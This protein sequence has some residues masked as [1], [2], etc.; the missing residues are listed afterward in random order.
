MNNLGFLIGSLIFS[1]FGLWV[2]YQ[3]I[4]AIVWG[5]PSK[6]WPSTRGKIVYSTIERGPR[7][8]FY[9]K[10]MFE[11]KVNGVTYQSSRIWWG[12]RLNMTR[13][14]AE[15][16]NAEYRAGKKVQV[17]YHPRFHRIGSLKTGVSL[18]WLIF[19]LIFL[20]LL[21]GYVGLRIVITNLLN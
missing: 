6:K 13:K 8:T 7:R 20:G 2:I 15:C 5:N 16:F 9:P 11:Y 21:P 18:V 19:V 4:L 12:L 10:V 17:Y 14:G 3:Q 1:G